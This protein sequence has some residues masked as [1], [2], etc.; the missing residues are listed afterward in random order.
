M[1]EA[2][3]LPS[4]A[5][6]VALVPS[7]A[8]AVRLDEFVLDGTPYASL[9]YSD[10]AFPPNQMFTVYSWDGQSWSPA[11]DLSR[12]AAGICQSALQD[13]VAQVTCAWSVTDLHTLIK[14]PSEQSSMPD[15]IAVTLG[16]SFPPGNSYFSVLV[17]IGNNSRGMTAFQTVKFSARGGIDSVFR[18]SANAVFIEADAY[19]SGDP[20]CCPG[21][22]EYVVLSWVGDGFV[23][24]ARCVRDRRAFSSSPCV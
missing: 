1:A 24:S 6:I 19:G 20:F 4:L 7:G 15:L 14:F 11:F 23:E 5:D 9:S 21:S 10:A 3:T 13:F 12:T 8:T 22:F 2:Q 18:L 16:F 17:L